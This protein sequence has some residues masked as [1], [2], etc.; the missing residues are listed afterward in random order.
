M[1]VFDV[2]GS[3][4]ISAAA[5]RFSR[6]PSGMRGR[7]SLRAINN[8]TSVNRRDFRNENKFNDVYARVRLV[9]RRAPVATIFA[10]TPSHSPAIV[11]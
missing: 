4:S 2:G 5:D 8:R 11:K 10:R 9:A 3:D 6:S 7:R 1:A